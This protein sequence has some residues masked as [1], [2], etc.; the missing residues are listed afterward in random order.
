MGRYPREAR[1]ARLKCIECNAPVVETVEGSYACVDCG[2]APISARSSATASA[3][4]DARSPA[5]D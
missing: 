2:A 1:D 4:D 5:D 3:A